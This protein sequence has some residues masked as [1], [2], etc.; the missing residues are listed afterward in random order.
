MQVHGKSTYGTDC[1]DC[2]TGGIPDHHCKLP[3]GTSVKEGIP[4]ASSTGKLQK[5]AMYNHSIAANTTQE[6]TDGWE[7]GGDVGPTIVSK[8]TYMLF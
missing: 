4:L 2:I 6:C 8:V 3:E 1:S 5:C 7:Y